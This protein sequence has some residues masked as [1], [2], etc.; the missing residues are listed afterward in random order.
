VVRWFGAM[1][2]QDYPTTLPAKRALSLA[3]N[4]AAPHAQT[5]MKFTER[6]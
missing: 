6:I 1:Q 4:R 3:S 2:A 5:A